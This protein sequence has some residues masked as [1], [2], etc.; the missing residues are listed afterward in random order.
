GRA[1]RRM[2]CPFLLLFLRSLPASPGHP[3]PALHVR[4]LQK[5]LLLRIAPLRC[6][7]FLQQV[8]ANDRLRQPEPSL[9]FPRPLHGIPFV[10]PRPS[11]ESGWETSFLAHKKAALENSLTC[12][13]RR[14]CP[15]LLWD[16]HHTALFARRLSPRTLQS[17]LRARLYPASFFSLG[18]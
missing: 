9:S 12:C 2:C 17:L 1:L 16:G 14:I 8:G 11:C 15:P 6:R 3:L 7:G 18:G 5:S 10:S 4:C 13:H